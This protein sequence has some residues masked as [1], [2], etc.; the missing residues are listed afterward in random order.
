MFRLIVYLLHVTFY[1]E[2]RSIQKMNPIVSRVPRV[3]GMLFCYFHGSLSQV[4]LESFINESRV[5]VVVIVVVLVVVII[6][7]VVVV[8]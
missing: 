4:R 2:I 6:V 1:C 3:Y 8:L 7:V 5:V